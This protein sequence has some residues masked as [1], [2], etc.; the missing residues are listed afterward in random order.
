[1]FNVA[2]E[3]VFEELYEDIPCLKLKLF[4]AAETLLGEKV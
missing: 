1:M 2:Y 3:L 4:Y